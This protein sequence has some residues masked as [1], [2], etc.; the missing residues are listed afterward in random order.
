MDAMAVIETIELE[1]VQIQTPYAMKMQSGTI[2]IASV[3]EC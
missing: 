3:I 1:I 2:R